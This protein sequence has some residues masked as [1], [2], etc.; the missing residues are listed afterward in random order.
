MGRR[1]MEIDWDAI[2]SVA[3]KIAPARRRRSE[4]MKPCNDCKHFVPG[5]NS[6]AP[7]GA[8]ERKG[9]RVD[10]RALSHCNDFI[11]DDESEHDVIAALRARLA[12]V[13][14]PDRAKGWE[15]GYQHCKEEIAEIVR[16]LLPWARSNIPPHLNL[17]AHESAMLHRAEK[18]CA[19]AP[20]EEK[21]TKLRAQYR[22]AGHE[23]L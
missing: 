20:E 5:L 10:H 13:E 15:A 19:S 9:V 11:G 21:K 18:I 6:E 23:T 3:M 7:Y 17:S 2:E 14:R 22:D 16:F 8:C 1:L 4:G 12:E